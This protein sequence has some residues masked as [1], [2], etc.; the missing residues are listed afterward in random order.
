MIL[1]NDASDLHGKGI[2]D[3][4]LS[5]FIDGKRLERDE[6]IKMSP[7]GTY[8]AEFSFPSG[9][10]F[11]AKIR[12][13]ASK[14]SYE[15]TGP[16]EIEEIVRQIQKQGCETHCLASRNSVTKR[17]HDSQCSQYSDLCTLG[18]PLDR[19]RYSDQG[20]S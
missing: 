5:I 16:V 17:T 2:E 12:I 18:R 7:S 14:P 19:Y 13:E 4:R 8:E 15:T 6:N 1:I 11:R 9:F 20:R 3:A 10:L